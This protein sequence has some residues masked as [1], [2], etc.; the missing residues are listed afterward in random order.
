[1]DIYK[2]QN[3][4]DGKQRKVIDP[5]NYVPFNERRLIKKKTA[6]LNDS[7]NANLQKADTLKGQFSE[8]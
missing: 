5:S 6:Y 2:F 1:M 8:L 7:D 4:K 3:D